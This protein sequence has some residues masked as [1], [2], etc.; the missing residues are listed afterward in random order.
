MPDATKIKLHDLRQPTPFQLRLIADIQSAG[1]MPVDDFMR[2]C[3][4][5]YYNTQHAFGAKGDFITAP[6][7]SQMFGE[8]VAVWIMQ[9]WQE[10]GS[11]KVLRLIELGPGDGTLMADI[12][13]TLK[14]FKEFQTQL[15][16][17]LIENSAR[18][19]DLQRE[20]LSPYNVALN[21]PQS[22]DDVE[23]DFSIVIANEFFDALPIKQFRKTKGAWQERCISYDADNASLYFTTRVPQIDVAAIMPSDFLNAQDGSIFEISP[24]SLSMIEKI[25]RRLHDHAGAALVIDYGYSTPGLGDS[26]QGISKQKYADVLDNPGAHDLTAHV[27]FAT[28]KTVA[29]FLKTQ[30]IMTQADFLFAMGITHRGEDLKK[31]NQ[32]DKLHKDIDQALHRLT[33]PDAMGHLFKVLIL[34][35]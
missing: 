33:S 35:A 7:V 22:I 12:L 6:G 21:W 24:E 8:M 14:S 9:R 5:E 4:G 11:P 15:S 19:R 18:L 34:T 31:K 17:S 1:M 10:A 23:P 26:L 25:A 32:N 27:D 20:K 13:R 28:L 30:Q 29:S 16:V 2:A 3:A